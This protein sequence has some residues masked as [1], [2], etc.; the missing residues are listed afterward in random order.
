MTAKP[1]PAPHRPPPPR[2]RALPPWSLVAAGVLTG[3]LLGGG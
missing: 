1:T 2:L 3:G